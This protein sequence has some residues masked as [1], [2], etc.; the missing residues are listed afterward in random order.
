[1]TLL[2]TCASSYTGKG[3]ITG[4]ALGAQNTCKSADDLFK[5]DKPDQDTSHYSPSGLPSARYRAN[6][7]GYSKGIKG[8]KRLTMALTRP[9]SPSF[10]R[11]TRSI[12]MFPLSI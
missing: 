2:S 12:G 3:Y 1:M 9:S 4:Y 11:N 6:I 10:M 8:T 7:D 5:P